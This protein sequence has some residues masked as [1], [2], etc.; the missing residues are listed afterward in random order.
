MTIAIRI[1]QII[2]GVIALMVGGYALARCA[3]F[4]KDMRTMWTLFSSCLAA[5][6]TT[7]GLLLV[8]AAML[9]FFRTFFLEKTTLVLLVAFLLEIVLTLAFYREPPHDRSR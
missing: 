4:V 2:L 6:G 9:A 3:K 8:S 5:M 1:L 7:F